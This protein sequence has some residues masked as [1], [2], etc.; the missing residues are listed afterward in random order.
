MLLHS[1]LKFIYFLHLV[2]NSVMIR[3]M[4]VNDRR[5][6]TLQNAFA[7]WLKNWMSFSLYAIKSFLKY[8]FASFLSRFYRE[9]NFMLFR[10][11]SIWGNT[12]FVSFHL[13]FVSSPHRKLVKFSRI[14]VKTRFK[15]EFHIGY[16]FVNSWFRIISFW[17]LF[18]TASF[19]CCFISVVYDFRQ[20]QCCNVSSRYACNSHTQDTVRNLFWDKILLSGWTN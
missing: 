13:H 3:L 12:N 5:R 14:T 9:K 17:Y 1:Q 7:T 4:V 6:W 8:D 15:Y 18:S 2:H 10:V 19:S 20:S 16:T 11:D